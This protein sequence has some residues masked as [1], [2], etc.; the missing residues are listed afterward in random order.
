M[1]HALQGDAPKEEDDEHDV[2]VDGGH[3]D[4]LRIL[5]DALDDAEVHEG[6]GRQQAAPDPKV[7]VIRVL[8]V[9]GDVQ[10]L[11]VPKVLRGATRLFID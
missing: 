11:A 9:V 4:D 5:G 2:G 8:D 1:L 3:V 6:P 7:K 10:G